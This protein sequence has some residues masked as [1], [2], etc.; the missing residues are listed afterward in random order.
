MKK[1]MK[2]NLDSLQTAE[3][4]REKNLESIFRKCLNTGK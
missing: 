4:R 1:K 3:N 2:K